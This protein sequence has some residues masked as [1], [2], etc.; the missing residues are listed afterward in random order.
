MGLEESF[1]SVVELLR[2]LRGLAWL[3]VVALQNRMEVAS[4]LLLVSRAVCP[5]KVDHM[6]RSTC[7]AVIEGGQ[8]YACYANSSFFI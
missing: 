5:K 4:A 3:L 8:C 6:K 1:M 2:L 7:V